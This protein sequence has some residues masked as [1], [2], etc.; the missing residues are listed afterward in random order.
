M[1]QT[2]DGQDRRRLVDIGLLAY[3]LGWSWPL[4]TVLCGVSRDRYR[5]SPGNKIFLTAVSILLPVLIGR[6]GG[7]YR[8]GC[9]MALGWYSA[10]IVLVMWYWN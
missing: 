1:L 10:M 6:F 8:R 4:V 7:R 9:A 2:G 5:I 3:V